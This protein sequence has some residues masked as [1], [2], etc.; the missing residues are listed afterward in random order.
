MLLLC[1]REVTCRLGIVRTSDGRFHRIRQ[2]I[3]KGCHG[4]GDGESQIDPALCPE[5]SLRAEGAREIG[6]PDTKETGGDGAVNAEVYGVIDPPV[7]N[8]CNCHSIELVR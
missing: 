1:C 5:I 7:M 8:S 6:N 4:G 3:D 2:E